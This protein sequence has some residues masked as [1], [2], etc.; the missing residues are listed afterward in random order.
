VY[1][2]GVPTSVRTGTIVR[3]GLRRRCGRCGAGGIFRSHYELRERCPRCGYRF[4]RDEAAFTGVWLLNYSFTIIPLLALLAYMV[5]VLAGG[6]GV[7]V[8]AFVAAAAAIV[9]V[10]P[11]VMYPIAKSLWASI[12]LAM[13]PLEPVEEAEAAL[14]AEPEPAPDA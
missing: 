9:I 11:I 6:N 8:W 10:L 1:R 7:N 5:A 12:D 3:R 4:E 13:R 2:R 14:Y